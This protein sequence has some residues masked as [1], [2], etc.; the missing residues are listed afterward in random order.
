MKL[1]AKAELNLAYTAV[2]L[3]L[4][5]KLVAYLDPEYYPDIVST[6][7]AT[8]LG[9]LMFAGLSV[10]IRN[11]FDWFFHKYIEPHIKTYVDAV[12]TETDK[13][14]SDIKLGLQDLASNLEMYQKE[15]KE[16]LNE[17]VLNS[18]I[19][20]SEPDYLKG[21][22]YLFHESAY[23]SHCGK[24]EGLYGHLNKEIYNYFKPEVPHRSQHNQ[25]V[26]ISEVGDDVFWHETTRF[27]VHTIAFDNNYDQVKDSVKSIDY[28][29]KYS[30]AGK[31]KDV[32]KITLE[33]S[34]DKN[35]TIKLHDLIEIDENEIKVK[36]AEKDKLTVIQAGN[37]VIFHF[38]I[39]IPLNSH[40]TKVHIIEESI[41]HDDENSYV[42]K[43]LEP[44]YGSCIN[45]SLPPAWEILEFVVPSEVNYG[46]P[47]RNVVKNI[48]NADI[49]DWVLPGIIAACN[50]KRG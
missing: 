7:S 46:E 5:T 6:G 49:N 30:T 11:I 2:G 50:W 12:K 10:I 1:F 41:L 9:I 47:N 19:S 36:D 44:T 15:S 25:S 27:E 26:V 3:Y 21:A 34:I 16:L 22:F 39:N 29:L 31:F 32:N 13:A 18:I 35:P 28:L 45:V 4:I 43:R 42:I 38:H 17:N 14:T 48:R 37:Q 33:I 8:A 40:K 23:G 24:I 20:R